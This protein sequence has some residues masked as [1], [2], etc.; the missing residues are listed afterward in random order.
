VKTQ[1]H[2]L[3]GGMALGLLTLL[4]GT[5]AASAASCEQLAAADFP[6]IKIISATS[7]SAGGLSKIPGLNPGLVRGVDA[8]T[9]PAFCRVIAQSYPVP[10]SNIGFEVWLPASGWTGRMIGTGNGAL[11]GTIFYNSMAPLLAEGAVTFGTDTGHIE[12]KEPDGSV[13]IAWTKNPEALIDFGYRSMHESTEGARE[14]AASFYGKAPSFSY[15]AG[16]STGGRQGI[17]GAQRYPDDYDGVLI[18]APALDWS[19]QHAAQLFEAQQTLLDSSHFLSKDTL[20]IVK[21]AATKKCDALDGTKDG[22]IADPRMCKFDPGSLQCKSGQTAQCLSTGQVDAL[23]KLYAGPVNDRGDKLFYGAVPGGEVEMWVNVGKMEDNDLNVTDFKFVND[24]PNFNWRTMDFVSQLRKSRTSVGSVIDATDTD[25]LPFLLRGKMIMY[26]GW[27]DPFM[28]PERTIAYYEGVKA[29]MGA[30]AAD[31][32]RLYMVPNMG[33]CGGGDG[34]NE[35]GGA[36]QSPNS[37]KDPQHNALLALEAWVE[38]SRAP[39]SIVATRYE[40]SS[41]GK[42]GTTRPLCP[43]PAIARW[44]GKGSVDDAMNFKCVVSKSSTPG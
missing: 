13:S 31:T 9:L 34:P 44:T 16:C 42:P 40:K 30:R 1:N 17:M 22:L 3:A 24:D 36:F 43:Y 27:N 7:V 19:S 10:G 15:Y 41:G 21:A 18:G 25:L 29:L 39:R 37:S 4:L 38:Q 20:A 32:M 11:A 6:H 28:K 5:S 23:R 2:R 8:A 35:F 26:Q 14:I 12:S 33:H